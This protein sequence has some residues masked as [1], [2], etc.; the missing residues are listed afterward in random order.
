MATRDKIAALLLGIG[1][2]PKNPFTIAGTD[3]DRVFDS[4]TETLGDISDMLLE[5][6][7]Q[8]Y[9]S[10]ATFYPTPGDLRSKA[11]EL[12]MHAMCIPTAAEAWSMFLK[13]ERKPTLPIRCDQAIQ[14]QEAAMGKSNGDYWRIVQQYDD[15]LAICSTCKTKAEL[16]QYGH[17]IVER[18]VELIGGR[19]VILTDNQAADR[20]RFY[21]AYQEVIDR[22]KT[23]SGLTPQVREVVEDIR[24]KA[25]EKSEPERL[26]TQLT[27]KVSK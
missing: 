13:S 10:A 6:A 18:V 21:Q 1:H 19:D 7:V 22:E 3:A 20:A 14:L 15:H 23:I 4:Y 17:P 12:Q 24:R 16:Y 27:E 26:I 11:M 2:L 25:L 8:A 5:A 9:V